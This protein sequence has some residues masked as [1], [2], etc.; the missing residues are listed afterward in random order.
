MSGLKEIRTRINSITSTQKITSAL[1]MVSAAK[2]HKAQETINRFKPYSRKV[3]DVLSQVIP[4]A[5]DDILEQWFNE[6]KTVNKI[7]LVILSSN[8]SMC[9]GFNQNLFKKVM[10]EGPQLFKEEWGTNELHLFCLG[11]KGGDFFS[12]RGFNVILNDNHITNKPN[13][14]DS[15][16]ILSGILTSYETKEYDAVY[17]AYNEFKNPAVQVSIVKRFLP[18]PLPDEIK[19]AK[20]NENVTFEPTKEYI[21]RVLIPAALKTFFFELILENAI[22]EHGARMTAM[23]QATENAIELNKNLKLQYNKARQAA[24]TKEILEIVSGAEALTSKSS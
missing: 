11:K 16:E 13:Y 6:P 20:P 15:T 1:K 7:A 4:S 18:Y 9:G 24:I 17:V 12:K 22:G 21:M 19:H 23:H 10:D 8:S 3:L 14:K 5:S 2:F